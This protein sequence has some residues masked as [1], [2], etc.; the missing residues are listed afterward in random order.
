M[1]QSARIKLTLWYLVIIMTVSGFFSLMVYRGFTKEMG[2]GFRFQ[3]MN[4]FSE[5][6]V[7]VQTRDGF[8]SILPFF[9]YPDEIPPDEFIEIINLAKRRFALQLLIM[10]GGILILAG[11]AGYF[12]AGKTLHPIEEMLKDQKRFVTDA[13][14]EL[15]TPLTSMKTGVE[16]ALRDKKLN[17]KDAKILMK[18][19]LSEINKMKYFSDSLLSLSRF[20]TGGKELTMEMVDLTEAARIAIEGNLAQAKE[21]KIVV[22]DYFSDVVIKGNPQSLVELISILINNAIKYSS[23]GG[24][25][26]VTV[27]KNKKQ[28]IIEV[29]DWGMGISQKDIPHIFDRFYRAD[30]SRNKSKTDGYG[31]GLSIA[32]SIV[33]V[34]GGEIKVESK[35]EKGSKFIVILP[36]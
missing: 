22:K 4:P 16:V 36:R 8:T 1:F 30:A 3:S 15:R 11:T 26:D 6:R 20:E 13:S 29:S 25:I 35:V 10:N 24:L 21:K 19:N 9:I 12:L 2:R 17:L 33:D 32:Q 7:L 18:S 34:H 31:L 23:P 28:A 5:R 27:N 14:H